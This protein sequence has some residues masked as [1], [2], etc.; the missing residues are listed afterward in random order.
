MTGAAAEHTPDSHDASCPA[1]ADT[2]ATPVPANPADPDDLDD[3][4]QAA[5]TGTDG[6]ALPAER[7]PLSDRDRY[8]PL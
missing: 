8:E 7:A 2:T 4:Q 6:E 3:S 1:L 5:S